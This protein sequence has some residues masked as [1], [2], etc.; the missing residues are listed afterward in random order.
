MKDISR[1]MA[2][3]GAGIMS[4]LIAVVVLIVLFLLAGTFR[5]TGS[6][7]LK[8]SFEAKAFEQKFPGSDRPDKLTA[9]QRADLVAGLNAALSDADGATRRQAGFALGEIGP[10]ALP[11]VPTLIGLLRSGDTAAGRGAVAGLEGIAGLKVPK[12]VRW[13]LTDEALNWRARKA[14]LRLGT[15]EAL[16]A[17]A[18]YTGSCPQAFR[19]PEVNWCD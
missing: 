15:P 5:N 9:E 11:A 4:I 6:T 17:A 3:R 18:S 10:E 1:L 14:L 8:K 13:T 2:R 19:A 7:L 16:K 12:Q